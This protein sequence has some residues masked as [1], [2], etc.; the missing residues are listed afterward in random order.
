VLWRLLLPLLPPLQAICLVSVHTS[1]ATASSSSSS[2][3]P[4]CHES[5][6]CFCRVRG[7]V[8][9]GFGLQF[10]AAKG[11]CTFCLL[12]LLL[13][14]PLAPLLQRQLPH[15]LLR[16]LAVLLPHGLLWLLLPPLLLWQLLH[17]SSLH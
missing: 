11:A 10:P 3:A 6:C 15:G 1:I 2:A 8:P 12:L 17:G 13:L 16:Q 14:E 4:Q 5:A 9:A 7:W